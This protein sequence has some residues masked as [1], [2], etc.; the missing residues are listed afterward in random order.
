METQNLS[1][2]AASD[3]LGISV[4]T[5]ERHRQNRTGPIYLRLG[6]KVFY[7]LSDLTRW[8]EENRFV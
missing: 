7:R 8:Q 1:T 4:R 3:W 2:K 5:L 6:K